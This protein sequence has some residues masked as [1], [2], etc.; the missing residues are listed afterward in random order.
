M[1]KNTI[2]KTPYTKPLS[3]EELLA[4][5]DDDIAHD[6]DNPRTTQADWNNSFVSHSYQ[7]LRQNISRRGLQKAS[8]KVSTTVRFDPDVLAAFKSMGKGWQTQMNKA[9]KE[10]LAT[11]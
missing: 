2:G 5:P 3:V 11:H 1:N 8:T 10:W 9:L 6:D 4:M 7:E